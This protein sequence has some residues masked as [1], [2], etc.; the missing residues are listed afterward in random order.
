[1]VA[2]PPCVVKRS[3]P[4]L[5]SVYREIWETFAMRRT[6]GVAHASGARL[7]IPVF[8][9][10]RTKAA[11]SAA[12]PAGILA[13]RPSCARESIVA[14]ATAPGCQQGSITGYRAEAGRVGHGGAVGRLDNLPLRAQ[15]PPH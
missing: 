6:L 2:D 12:C 13:A 15:S 9:R 1:M 4:G 10:V 8:P 5:L 7:A 3:G 14:S 11:R